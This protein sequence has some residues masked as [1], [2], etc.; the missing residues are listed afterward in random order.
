[1]LL[2][3]SLFSTP[4]NAHRTRTFQPS[5]QARRSRD[6][7]RSGWFQ[8]TVT[9]CL[10]GLLFSMAA[11]VDLAAAEWRFQLEFSPILRSRPFTGRVTIFFSAAAKEPRRGPNWLAPEP[12]V[13]LDV[14][15]WAP[16]TPLLVSESTPGLLS[17]PRPM[18]WVDLQKTP[19]VQA[20]ARFNPTDWDVGRGPGNAIS[21]VVVLPAVSPAPSSASQPAESSSEEATEAAML[22]PAEPVSLKLVERI[23]PRN[24]TPE[25]GWRWFSVSSPKLTAFHQRPISV[26]AAVKLPASY[27]TVTDPPR[28]YPMVFIIPGFGGT[29]HSAPQRT[30]LPLS[31][32]NQLEFVQVVLDPMCP[33]GHHVFADSANNGPWQQALLHEFLPAFEQQFRTWGTAAGRLLT[34]HSSGGWSSLWL[35]ISAPDTFGGVW[36]TAPDPVDFHDFQQID[37][38]ANA[39]NAHRRP[40]GERWP[41]VRRGTDEVLVWFDDFDK[42]EQVLGPGGQLQSFEAVFSPRGADGHPVR[43]WN[44]QT[45]AIDPAVAAAWQQYDIAHVLE[46]QWERLGPLLKGKLHVFMGTQDTFYLEGAT[47]RLKAVL[48]RLGSDAVIELHEGRDHRSL[49]TGELQRRIAD[50]MRATAATV[51]SP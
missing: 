24:W 14:V 16:S 51:L 23:P 13:S 35:Q 29:A 8:R 33:W 46:S 12:F 11:S 4:R 50:E 38:Y 1:M 36:S 10:T 41:L 31:A 28:R 34:G 25:T 42:M 30:G 17:F 6:P 18:T 20:V 22:P 3:M 32:E 5:R 49:L 26:T 15:D 47:R 19:R 40:S 43:L 21:Q 27:E 45:G 39:A 9:V 7:R 44:R 37:I 48:D 2:G